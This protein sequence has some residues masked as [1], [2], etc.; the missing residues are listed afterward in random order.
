MAKVRAIPEGLHSITTQLSVDGASDAIEFYKKAFGA[1]ELSRFPDPSGKKVWHA[2][3]RIGDATF[4]VNDTFP[5]MG[6]GGTKAQLWIYGDNV[7]AA[8]ERAVGAGAKVMMPLADM[9]WGDRIGTVTDRWG[10]QWTIGQH[11][12]D[13]SPEEMRKAGEEFAKNMKK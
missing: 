10:N 3:L 1:E 7:D 12:K 2:A 11:V 9:F 5:E 4:F 13:M 6:S 8:F